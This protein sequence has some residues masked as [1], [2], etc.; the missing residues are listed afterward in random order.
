ML[1]PGAVANFLCCKP[2]LL[3]TFGSTEQPS[4]NMYGNFSFL[5]LLMPA[6]EKE[7]KNEK[8]YVNSA[9]ELERYVSRLL[10]K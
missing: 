10:C 7:E 1:R 4:C 5:A 9:L 8:H 2:F 3:D 6:V